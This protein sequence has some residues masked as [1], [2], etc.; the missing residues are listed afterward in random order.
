MPK[1]NLLGEKYG[2]LTVIEEAEQIGGRT[3]WKC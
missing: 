3:A 1:L 2:L